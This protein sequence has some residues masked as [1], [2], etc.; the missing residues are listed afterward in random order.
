VSGPDVGGEDRELR[1]ILHDAIMWPHKYIPVSRINEPMAD[2]TADACIAALRS[3]GV[4]SPGQDYWQEAA[5]F[6]AR[7]V[8][9]DVARRYLSQEAVDAL[10]A[11]RET[12]EGG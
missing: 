4:L 3:A 9:C 10:S 7:Y 6:F 11:P 8:D 5:L 2:R 12:R 1:R